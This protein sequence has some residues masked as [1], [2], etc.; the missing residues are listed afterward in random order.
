MRIRG[1]EDAEQDI[2]HKKKK[3]WTFEDEDDTE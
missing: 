3:Y 1:I 2:K